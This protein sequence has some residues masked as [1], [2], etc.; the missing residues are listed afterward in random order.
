MYKM[1]NMYFFLE[2]HKMGLIF[3]AYNI[4]LAYKIF[5]EF[6]FYRKKQ[7]P[8]QIAF[9]TKE[10]LSQFFQSVIFE[11]MELDQMFNTTKLNFIL[12]D[13]LDFTSLLEQPEPQQAQHHQLPHL[14][15][16]RCQKAVVKPW[17]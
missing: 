9:Y 11:S 13:R 1:D 7:I 10:T 3:Y 6:T 4:S 5:D 15:H 16:Q 12:T 17:F 8:I 14:H 2:N